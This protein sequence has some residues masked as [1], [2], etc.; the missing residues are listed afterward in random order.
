MPDVQVASV[1]PTIRVRGDVRDAPPLPLVHQGQRIKP[2][3][4]KASYDLDDGLWVLREVTV[5]GNVL[6]P[7]GRTTRPMPRHRAWRLADLDSAPQWVREFVTD[8]PPM[9]CD[10]ECGHCHDDWSSESERS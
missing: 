10:F 5:N 7:D 2:T 6:S 8:N 4:I 9:M 3:T 1:S